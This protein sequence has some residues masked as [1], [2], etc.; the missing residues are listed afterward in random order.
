LIDG[1][2]EAISLGTVRHWWEGTNY[3]IEEFCVDPDFQ[4]LGTGTRFMGMIEDEI[5]RLG[6][7]GIFLQTDKDKPSYRFYLKNGYK[8][9]DMHVSMYKSIASNP[10]GKK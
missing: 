10:F 1:K 8:E 7:A 3:N 5:H 2:L 6:F 9:L 4:G